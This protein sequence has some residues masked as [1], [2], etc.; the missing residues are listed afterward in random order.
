MEVRIAGARG[1]E[2]RGEVRNG[3]E[4]GNSLKGTPPSEV[5]ISQ[6]TPPSNS[7]SVSLSLPEISRPV[8]FVYL[9]DILQPN[10]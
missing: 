4:G 9:L 7:L 6:F 8:C 2:K 3:E 10:H 1:F 5:H